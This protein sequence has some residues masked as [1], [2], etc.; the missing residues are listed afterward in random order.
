MP[1][2]DYY[3]ILGVDNGA[4]AEA[5]KKA[6]RAKARQLHPDVSKDPDAGKK[7]SELNAAYEVLSDPEKKA[8]Y[9]RLGHARYVSGMPEQ[10]ARAQDVDFGDLGSIIDAMFGG[11]GGGFG[12]FQTQQGG[13][14]TQHRRPAAKGKDLHLG[15]RVSLD[16]VYHG[17]T[18]TLSVP[19][20]E[21]YKS[22]E[23]KVPMGV[24]SGRAGDLMVRIEVER[25]ARFTR[26]DDGLDLSTDLPL[27]IAEATL[28]AKV[29][30]PT[31]EGKVVTLTIPPAT[32]SE[33]RFRIG[34]HGMRDTGG[35]RGDLFAKVRIVPP[36]GAEISEALRAELEKLKSLKEA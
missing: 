22:I 30:V 5:I 34:G 6:F 7:F 19:S 29:D 28:G 32:I 33:S 3:Q 24:K 31:I 2:G 9:D 20:G 1:A 36:S 18:K 4:D 12:G 16:D 21:G 15:L 23:V 25:D 10:Q 8:K 17:A 13:A 26:I 35:K 27:S 14:R 11:R